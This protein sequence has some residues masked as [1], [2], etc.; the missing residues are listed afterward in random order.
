MQVKPIKILYA[1]FFFWDWY[2]YV[3]ILVVWIASKIGLQWRKTE[4][5]TRISRAT[6][7]TLCNVLRPSSNEMLIWRIAPW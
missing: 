2:F 3:D 1:F 6:R 4:K 5:S 7:T